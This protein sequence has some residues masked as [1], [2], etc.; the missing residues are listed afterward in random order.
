[1]FALVIVIGPIKIL[2][3]IQNYF[4]W[5]EIR[6]RNYGNHSGPKTLNIAGETSSRRESRKSKKKSKWRTRRKRREKERSG[7]INPKI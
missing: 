4:L 2:I 3:R 5:D 7:K 6:I 1:L